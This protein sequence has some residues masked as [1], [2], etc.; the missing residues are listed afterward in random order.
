MIYFIADNKTGYTRFNDTYEFVQGDLTK[1][2][3]SDY[4]EKYTESQ[5]KNA[6]NLYRRNLD[7]SYIIAGLWYLLNVVDASVDAHLFEFEVSDDL[8]LKIE[9]DIKLLP[10]DYKPY[11]GV[12]LSF[13]LPFSKH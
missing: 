13:T 2:P 9:P 8:T 3:Y 10:Q 4:A 5:L 1:T 6:K 11:T 7:Y 12:K